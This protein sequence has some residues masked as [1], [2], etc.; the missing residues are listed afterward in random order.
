M[1]RQP[2]RSTRPAT[3]T[4]AGSTTATRKPN[5]GNSRPNGGNGRSKTAFWPVE[6]V[7]SGPLDLT[8]EGRDGDDFGLAICSRCA[9]VI[10]GSDRARTTHAIF[11]E[12]IDGIDQRA[13]R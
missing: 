2:S 5:G 13:G 8:L 1:P 7:S 12:Q 3:T 9:A 10:P 6:L 11:H 4:K